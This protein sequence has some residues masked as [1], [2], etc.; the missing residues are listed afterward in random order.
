[1]Y[2]ALYRKWRPKTF[3]DVIGQAHIT[4]TLKRQVAEGR[5]S[6]AYL[7]TGTRGTGKT[8]CAKILA[9]AVN[10]ED[11]Q[12]GD[13]CNR[14]P[15][16]LGIENGTF[17]DVLELD[18]ASN[19]GVDQVRAL[20]DEAI[21]SPANVKKRVY[22]V[23]EVHMLSVAAFNALLKILEE[24]PEHLVFILATTELHKVPATILSRC[25]RYSFKRILPREVAGRLSYVARQEG[26]DLHADGAELL[27][28]LADGALR[29][30][31]S[32][33]DQCAAAGGAIDGAA[34]LDV[35]GLAGNLQTAQLMEH[36]LQR[37]AQSALLLLNQLYDGGKDVGAVLSELS[38][39]TRDLLL[40]RTAPEGGAALLSG[41]YDSAA[42]DKLQK[43]ASGSRLLYLATTLQRA[44]ADLYYSSN[45][46]TDAELC[47]LRLCDESL[48]GDL[49]ALTAR[50]QKLEDSL[51]RL[52]ALLGRNSAA[53]SG[54]GRAAPVEK[55]NSS[56]K[57]AP[58]PRSTPVAKAPPAFEDH[59]PWGEEPPPPEEPPID[60]RSAP[61][62]EDAEER[63]TPSLEAPSP[64]REET[65]ASVAASSREPAATPTPEVS[66]S[67]PE[68]ASPASLESAGGAEWWL[69]LA[70]EC[71]GRLPP[72]YRVFLDRCGGELKDG[73][74]TVYAPDEITRGRLD[75][76]RVLGAL[77][78]LSALR[79]GGPVAVRLTV[80]SGPAASP[81]DK[82]EDLIRRGSRLDNFT[83]R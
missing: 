34:V 31:L 72:M 60:D 35:L 22:I 29:D 3:S 51:D 63:F 2:Q 55:H 81:Q 70:E 7:F 73:A 66:L 23:D 15:S 74:L 16:C 59:P 13:P 61:P 79:A 18:A 21:Y 20:R 37:N 57:A 49:T 33:L 12:D 52:P 32:L 10:C 39:L 53:P 14:C 69:A 50:I 38:V 5:T 17:L 48:S 1:M 27:S 42:L 41:G 68:T 80:G 11:P 6:H 62:W 25:Q 40:R 4:E 77:Q 78:E 58:I 36:I 47:L 30:G 54:Q 67:P 64:P 76:D 9:K 44:S 65:N 82:M 8:T 46:R 75:N 26:I 56:E 71:K 83:I 19:N 45:R 24:P 28:R 43:D